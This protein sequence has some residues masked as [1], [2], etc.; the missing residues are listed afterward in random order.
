MDNE[1]IHIPEE[2]VE[3]IDDPEYSR[4]LSAY[5]HQMPDVAKPLINERKW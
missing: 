4:E 2:D 5:F 1:V 3:A